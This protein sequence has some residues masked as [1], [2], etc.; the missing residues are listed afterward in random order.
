MYLLFSDGTLVPSL[1][2]TT[3]FLLCRG[4]PPKLPADTPQD[5]TPG[6]F[7]MGEDELASERV[8]RTDHANI[9]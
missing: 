7:S 4:A 8:W 9:N 5:S 6:E 3:A 2:Y 1:L